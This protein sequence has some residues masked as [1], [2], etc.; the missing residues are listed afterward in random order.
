M[1]FGGVI[2]CLLALG[3]LKFVASLV[4][5]VNGRGG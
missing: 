2:V 3:V 1:T 4:I 5:P